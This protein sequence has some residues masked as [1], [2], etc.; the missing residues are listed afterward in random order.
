MRS[1][2]PNIPYSIYFEIQLAQAHRWR[3]NMY[4]HRETRLHMVDCHTH[5][6]CL[7]FFNT[8]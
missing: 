1:N 6:I 5:Y 8:R 7:R 4:S 3:D 2:N